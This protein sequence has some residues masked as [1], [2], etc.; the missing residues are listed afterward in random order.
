VNNDNR[1]NDANDNGN[2]DNGDK[3]V[4]G[5]PE[6]ERQELLRPRREFEQA[7]QRMPQEQEQLLRDIQRLR[8]ETQDDADAHTIEMER[9]RQLFQVQ[10]FANHALEREQ[11]Q[12]QQA[13]SAEEGADEDT[14]AV[15]LSM[16]K[17]NP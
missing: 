4:V 7:R 9:R 16:V 14:D 8:Q 6:T 1:A 3:L 11:Q 2:N 10:A 5:Q 17:P 13:E 12:Q 15:S